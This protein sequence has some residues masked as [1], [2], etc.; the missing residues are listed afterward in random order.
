L[1]NPANWSYRTLLLAGLGVYIFTAFASQG[2]IQ[3]DEH[4]QVLEFADYKLGVTPAADLPWEFQ[5]QIRPALQPALAVGVIR[6]ARAAGILDP[7]SEAFLLRLI[8]AVLAILVYAWISTRLPTDSSGES[9]GRMLLALAILLWFVPTLSVRFSSENWSG[10][11]FLGGVGLLPLSAAEDRQSALRSAAAGL[12]LGFA[13]VFR[14]QV[15]FAIAGVAAWLLLQR[16][17]RW[18]RAATIIAGGLCAVAIGL[19]ADHWL[20]GNSVVTQWRYLEANVLRGKAAEFGVSPWWYYLPAFVMAAIPPISLILLLLAGYGMYRNPRHVFT[21]ASIPFVLAHLVVGHKELRFLFPMLFPFLWLVVSGW[22]E[23]RSRVTLGRVVKAGFAACV[24]INLVALVF[25][26]TRARQQAVPCWQYLYHYSSHR[27]A[28]L[29][30]EGSSPYQSGMLKTYF[31]RAPALTVRVVSTLAELH[32]GVRGGL[33]VGD[34]LLQRHLAAPPA[35][36]GYRIERA[37]RAF[38]DWMMHLDI[39]HWE[40]RTEIWTIYRV[41]ART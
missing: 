3:S 26:S 21:W 29:Y 19:A 28:V 18:T 30:A 25:V 33:E 11:A 5:Q 16:R 2:Y 7:F 40:E 32:N 17:L 41:A 14:F 20:Y 9:G 37:F 23:W 15:G 6:T 38:P 4:F 13:F 34:L 10:L 27:D 1:L 31:Y 8:S 22:K 39:G 36:P 35:I 24:V 12:L